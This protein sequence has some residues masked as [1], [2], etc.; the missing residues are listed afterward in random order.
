MGW[1]TVTINNDD[2]LQIIAARH[3]GH[4]ARW[5]EIALLN[6]LKPPYLAQNA[7]AGVLGYGDDILLPIPQPESIA[8][9]DD[10][11][12][13]DIAIDGNG[14]IMTN[15]ADIGTVSQETNLKQA[16]TIRAVTSRGSL[17]Y[18]P[19]YGSLAFTLIGN[20]NSASLADLAAFYTKSALTE[21]PRVDSI[22]SIS[23]AVT[24]DKTAIKAVVNPV[25]GEA[26]AFETI[27]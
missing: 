22:E 24:A 26:I 8:E 18:H 6:G 20:I 25:Y 7:S 2:T 10:R 5:V 14:F 1:R 17:L 23:A 11:F 16:L 21:D 3:L 9:H 12:L 4:A 13:T 19:E 27:L 15:G